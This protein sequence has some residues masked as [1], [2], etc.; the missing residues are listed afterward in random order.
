M[1]PIFGPNASRVSLVTCYFST[2]T[3]ILAEYPNFRSY[4]AWLLIKSYLI[5]LCSGVYDL[6]ATN[7]NC[8]PDQVDPWA[9]RDTKHS[10]HPC[11]MREVYS[12]SRHSCMRC[13]AF[14]YYVR[15]ISNTQICLSSP[16]N[17][18]GAC[19]WIGAI[20]PLLRCTNATNA[21]LHLSKLAVITEFIFQ[22]YL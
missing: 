14:A 18:V 19:R 5:L 6:L 20:C 22:C 7:G 1:A 21:N 3:Y 10:G 11:V 8:S 2:P 13:F 16:T 12:I 9:S 15:R 17:I 4:R